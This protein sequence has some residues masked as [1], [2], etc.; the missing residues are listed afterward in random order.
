MLRGVQLPL[1][2][3]RDVA[4]IRHQPL[5]YGAGLTVGTPPV[6]DPLRVGVSLVA[7]GLHQ[8]FGVPARFSCSP[9][10]LLASRLHHWLSRCTH[11]IHNQQ[12]PSALPRAFLRL[13]GA[14]FFDA[15]LSNRVRL[16]GCTVALATTHD[17]LPLVL[18]RGR[19]I[20]TG[21]SPP[22]YSSPNLRMQLLGQTLLPT[23]E[24]HRTACPGRILSTRNASFLCLR[25]HEYQKTMCTRG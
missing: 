2:H 12:V 14:A 8:R 6:G 1:R 9:R 25:S 15:G 16:A 3:A 11:R 24:S 17:L 20:K 18:A 5:L 4:E 13:I 21:L 23:T 10:P 7:S 19:S 22:W